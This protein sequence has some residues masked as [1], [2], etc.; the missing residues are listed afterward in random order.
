VG[1]ATSN[2][3]MALTGQEGPDTVEIDRLGW[4]QNA[5]SWSKGVE[6][7]AGLNIEMW[8]RRSISV[9]RKPSVPGFNLRFQ[10]VLKISAWIHP[11]DIR[12]VVAPLPAAGNDVKCDREIFKHLFQPLQKSVLSNQGNRQGL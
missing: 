7:A 2:G 1:T 8:G 9:G 3:A 5:T 4:C 12:H 6:V 11:I 10:S